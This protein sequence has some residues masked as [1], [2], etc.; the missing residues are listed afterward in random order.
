LIEPFF[1][2]IEEMI[3]LAIPELIPQAIIFDDKELLKAQLMTIPEEVRQALREIQI[4]KLERS[5]YN[6]KN[7]EAPEQ[8][9]ERN[10]ILKEAYKVISRYSSWIPFHWVMAFKRMPEQEKSLNDS[11]Q[12]Y[13]DINAQDQYGWTALHWAMAQ[14]NVP[15][16]LALLE[17]GADVTLRTG[18]LDKNDPYQN[19]TP[20]DI[21]LYNEEHAV[22]YNNHQELA[23][24]PVI[25]SYWSYLSRAEACVHLALLSNRP[26]TPLAEN[27]QNQ[28]F[29][30]IHARRLPPELEEKIME[31]ADM[32]CIEQVLPRKNYPKQN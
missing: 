8:T 13:P 25:S 28:R 18:T 17:A 30:E 32:P 21:A 3:K 9:K 2:R 20:L 12:T 24:K 1:A 19:M 16:T 26:L 22:K 6:S 15:C 11:A 29:T 4:I 14:H 27:N 10:K 31:F 5:R 7:R 23:W